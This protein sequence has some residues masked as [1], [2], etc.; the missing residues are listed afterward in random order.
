MK[1]AIITDW[2]DKYG[3]AERVVTA[4]CEVIDFDYYYAYINKMD[5]D[6]QILTFGNKKVDI[7]QS[8]WFKNFKPFFRFMMPLFPAVVSTFNRQTKKNQVGLVVSSSW[9]L[10]K[11]YR[12]GKE[13]HVC[14]LQA[15][16]FKYVWEEADMYFRGPLKLLSFLKKPLQRFDVRAAANPDILISNSLFVKNWVKEKYNR[17]S[18]VIYP[19][20]EVDDFFISDTRDDYFITVGRLEPYKRFDLI[21][22]AFKKNGKRLLVVGDGSVLPKLKKN[23]GDNIEF[24][25]FK[26]KSE[27]KHLLS[28]AR[29]FVYAGVEDFGIAVVEALASGTPVI[30]FSGG[31]SKEIIEDQ[32]TGVLYN[33][34]NVTAL[35]DA[36]NHFETVEE[37]FEAAEIRNKALK[38]SKQRFQREFL[39]LINATIS[40]EQ[41]ICTA[42]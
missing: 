9:V 42:N 14:Y 27:I 7:I 24:L 6:K 35:V 4:I 22:D 25:G 31:A 37:N 2:L 12:V 3:G 16:N 20:V 17:D 11:G 39:G 30:A 10:S 23:A 32:R 33:E 1:K 40:N 18:H 21:V 19:P 5:P 36:V 41:K 13:K 26:N 15:R 34:Q 38:F 8:N 29:A 28:K